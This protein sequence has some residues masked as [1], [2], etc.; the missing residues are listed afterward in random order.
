MDC[1][2]FD[3]Q[4]Y[5]FLERFDLEEKALPLRVIDSAQPYDKGVYAIDWIDKIWIFS[6]VVTIL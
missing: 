6:E 1:T 5:Q 4:L 2:R 3:N